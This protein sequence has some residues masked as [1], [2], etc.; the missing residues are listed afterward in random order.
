MSFERPE[1]FS[2]HVLPGEEPAEN[3]YNEITKAFRSFILEYRIDS[4]FIYRD[5]LRENLLIKNYFLKV[6]ADHLIA[7]NEELNKKLSDDPAEMIPLLKMPLL[8]LLKELLICS[9]TKF[10]KISQLVS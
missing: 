2:A 10:L 1:V 6:E 5:Q 7:F 8:I 9:M 4:Q 3:S